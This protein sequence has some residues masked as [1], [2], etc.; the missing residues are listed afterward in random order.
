MATDSQS[1]SKSK[2]L[3]FKSSASSSGQPADVRMLVDDQY[4]CKTAHAG[5]DASELCVAAHV[6][7]AILCVCGGGGGGGGV[8][9]CECVDIFFGYVSVTKWVIGMH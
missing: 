7:I 4:Y 2:A 5:I 6:C 9:M 8:C 3:H 1:A